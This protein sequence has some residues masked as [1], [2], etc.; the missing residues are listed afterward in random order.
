MTR[1]N[2]RRTAV[3]AIALGMSAISGANAQG[4]GGHGGDH[5]LFGLLD[6]VTLTDS[7]TQQIHADIKA[8]FAQ[9]RSTMQSLHAVEEQMATAMT[10]S[11]T[12]TAASLAPLLQQEETLR[13]QLDQDRLAVA[14]QVRQV[15]TA[16]QLA[17]AA[18]VHSQLAAL[19]QQEM[20]IAHPGT[21]AQ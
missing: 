8:G 10:A 17:Q 15:L 21:T 3:F 1:S 16:S 13:A 18:Q 14:L 11:G 20:A 9:A 4:W 2:N 6:G 19:H 12:P 5:R 7:Q